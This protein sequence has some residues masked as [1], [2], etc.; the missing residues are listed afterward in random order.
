M[1]RG[2]ERVCGYGADGEEEGEKRAR[3]EEVGDLE[4]VVTSEEDSEKE[5]RKG[6]NMWKKK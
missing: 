1:G 4:V 3:G 6:R 5:G 2:F